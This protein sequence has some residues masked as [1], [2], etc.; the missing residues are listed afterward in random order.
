[1]AEIFINQCVQVNLQGIDGVGDELEHVFHVAVVHDLP[2][3]DDCLAV[4]DAVGAWYGADYI[5]VLPTLIKGVQVVATS[6]AELDGPQATHD[7]A[8]LAGS[9]AE[10]PLPSSVTLC[11]K[12]S[13]GLSGRRHRGRFYTWPAVVSVIIESEFKDTYA[14][15]VIAQFLLLKAALTAIDAVLVVRSLA[16]PLGNLFPVVNFVAVDLHAD[17]QRRRLPGRGR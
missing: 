5:S 14:A 4:A 11:I 16:T 9:V 15:A 2:T 8:F 12:K 13:T 1:M 3:Y 6:A 7:L 10:A 17:S